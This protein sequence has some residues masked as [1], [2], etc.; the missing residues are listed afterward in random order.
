MTG[1]DAHHRER[2][3]QAPL[4][5][6]I[7]P[8]KSTSA[9]KH[10]THNRSRRNAARKEGH[11]PHTKAAIPALTEATKCHRETTADA[12]RQS[13]PTA[14]NRRDLT[15]QSSSRSPGDDAVCTT[16]GPAPSVTPCPKTFLPQCRSMPQ[17]RFRRNAIRIE[18]PT[19]Q[20]SRAPSRLSP[21]RC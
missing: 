20:Q 10:P 6:G 16:A 11:C 19:P 3:C 18:G 7:K 9:H 21:G 1:A 4:P 17:N 15:P 13:Y 12:T 8:S 14:Q 5:N 2:G